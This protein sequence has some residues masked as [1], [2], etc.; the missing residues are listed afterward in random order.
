[1]DRLPPY[2]P[3]SLTR[4]ALWLAVGNLVIAAA[5]V[6]ATWLALQAGRESD[7]TR[8]R[9]TTENLAASLSIEIGAELKQVDNAL[10]TLALQY[11]RTGGGPEALKRAMERA[12]ADQRSLLPQVDAIRMTDAHGQV[13]YGL[14]AEESSV[15]VGDRDYFQ[16][17][18][19]SDGVVIS[20][21]LFGRVLRKWGIVV[22]RR[23]E[24]GDG[25]F[26]GVVY[27]TLSTEHFIEGFKGLTIGAEG[28]ISLRTRSQRLIARYSA[29][30]PHSIRGVGD[31]IVSE[32]LM[33][34]M[35]A[36][37]QQ[38]WYMTKTKLDNIE[39][40]TCYRQVRGYPLTIFTGASTAD[41][42]A[43]WRGEVLQ[44]GGLAAVVILT[45]LGCSVL[46]F[47]QQRRDRR[48]ATGLQQLALEQALM[49]DNDMVGMMRL[50]GRNV[51]WQNRALSSLFGYAPG[52]LLGQPTRQLYLD[53]AS[54]REVGEAAYPAIESG[55]RYRQQLRMRRKDGTPV[56]IDLSG[57][58][59]SGNESLWMMID[60][61]A[62][63]ESEATARHLAVHDALT[64]LPNRVRF[65]ERL[66]GALTL[67]GERVGLVAVCWVDLDGFKELN[68]QFGHE[69]G[70]VVLRVVAQR[71]QAGVR[72]HDLVARMGGDEFALLLTALRGE[73]EAEPALRRMLA[74]IAEPIRLPDGDHASITASIGIAFAPLHGRQAEA[75]MRLAETAMT[76]AK[77]AGKRRVVSASS[78][79]GN[80]MNAPNSP[81]T[82][83]G[84]DAPTPVDAIDTPSS[85]APEPGTDSATPAGQ[86]PRDPGPP[87]VPDHS[88]DE[89]VAGE[90]DPGATL[91]GED[92]SRV[93]PRRS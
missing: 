29:A 48:A 74:S 62:L 36:N 46:V 25:S 79:P 12:L 67:L 51:V 84:P 66:A 56:W 1:M 85:P 58:S 69:A 71:L 53:E 87:A 2:V 34:K 37:P 70:D 55:R 15:S 50:R 10:Q 23:L 38:G 72:N 44:Q 21:P 8:A 63:K 45:V 11:R 77:R 18:R 82:S 5:I 30:E 39:R 65:T 86:R 47:L 32:D 78:M 4:L 24:A 54:F 61:S 20:E 19:D 93:P 60:V 17:A 33:R 73:H 49:L 59:V 14:A 88:F 91:D 90:E 7:L 68:D 6:A 81:A 9:E 75:L 13:I 92:S 83:V 80:A 40:I 28:A 57:A 89:S 31:V 52:E 27:T 43:A 42:L 41:F 26:A 64:G 22:A 76:M 35:A 3:R 16:R